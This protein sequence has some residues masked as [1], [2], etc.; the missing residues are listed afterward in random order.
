MTA[1]TR[2]SALGLAGSKDTTKNSQDSF[3]KT[4]EF[5]INAIASASEQ[6]T[7]VAAPAGNIQVI[8]AFIVVATAEASAAA[9]T[10]DVGIVGQPAVFLNDA[11]VAATGP[12]GTPI[13]AAIAGGTLAGAFIGSRIGETM[14]KVDRMEMN[15]ALEDMPTGRTK[16]WKNPDTGNRYAVKPTKTYTRTYR[17]DEQPCREYVTTATIGG[18]K[19]QIYG[20]AC[21]M[22]D[23]NWKVVS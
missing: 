15:H 13:A 19:E 12:V 14:D 8:S 11:S 16:R 17:G 23:G 2:F 20:R 5:D 9:K 4:Y 22:N 10:V 6:D 1:R 18:K 21:R 7:G 3:I